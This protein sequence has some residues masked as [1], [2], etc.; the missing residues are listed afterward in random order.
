MAM[1]K[2]K[3]GNEGGENSRRVRGLTWKRRGEMVEAQFLARVARLEFRVAKPWGD[4]DRYDFVVEAGSGF[5]RVQVKSTRYR[6]GEKYCV[7]L[8]RK[9]ETYHE[10][11]ID[12][13]VVYVEPED[14]WYV[15]PIEM[16]AS[17]RG[18][19]LYPW[20]RRSKFDRYR[21]AWCLLACSRKARGWTDIPVLCRGAKLRVQCAVC[22]RH[23]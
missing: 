9:G 7:V 15:L 19:G 23:H 13:L 5:W 21:E 14:L 12:F 11:E 1:H 4:S 20:L 10:D 16:V 6:R 2:G 17:L 3:L 18:L 22:P 8:Q